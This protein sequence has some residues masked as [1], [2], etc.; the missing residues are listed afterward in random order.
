MEKEKEDKEKEE[1][2]KMEKEKEEKDKEAQVKSSAPTSKSSATL[3]STT[4]SSTTATNSTTAKLDSPLKGIGFMIPP[5]ASNEI[6]EDRAEK[7]SQSNPTKETSSVLTGDSVDTASVRSILSRAKSILKT[8]DTGNELRRKRFR[9]A[10]PEKSLVSRKH[11]QKK[12]RISKANRNN[13]KSAIVT[14]KK[15]EEYPDN[16]ILKSWYGK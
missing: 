9:I 7:K 16:F 15:A 12:T 2:E 1:K 4:S 8:L 14:N 10:R 11:R 13:K 5:K 6:D 3:T